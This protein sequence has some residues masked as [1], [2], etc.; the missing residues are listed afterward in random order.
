MKACITGSFALILLGADGVGAQE[1]SRLQLGTPVRATLAA[2]GTLRMG[3]RRPEKE[4]RERNEK[5]EECA[6]RELRTLGRGG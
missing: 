6:R 1:A 5:K 3:V 2:G 4:E